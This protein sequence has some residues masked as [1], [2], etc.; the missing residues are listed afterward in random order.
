MSSKLKKWRMGIDSQNFCPRP[1]RLKLNQTSTRQNWTN[2]P[3]T[4]LDDTVLRVSM[5][6]IRLLVCLIHNKTSWQLIQSCYLGLHDDDD[7]LYYLTRSSLAPLIEGL[8]TR[9]QRPTGCLIFTGH[10]PQKSPKINGS[11]EKTNMQLKASYGSSPPCISVLVLGFT[12]TS[13]ALLFRKNEY[14]ER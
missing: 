3:Q 13:F 11:V 4:H 9:W 1:P 2:K 7:C 6:L 10:F 5:K 12:F 8:C 14:V